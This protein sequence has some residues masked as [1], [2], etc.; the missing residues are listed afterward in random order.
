M[1][2]GREFWLRVNDHRI[3]FKETNA[4]WFEAG[5]AWAAGQ[6]RMWY[7]NT[8]ATPEKFITTEAFEDIAGLCDAMPVFMKYLHDVVSKDI[9][10]IRFKPSVI[11]QDKLEKNFQDLRGRGGGAQSLT[12]FGL[13]FN[14]RTINMCMLNDFLLRLN[15]E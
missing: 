5:L 8:I 7:R 6:L 10:G 9:P 3:Y 14:L 11:T 1:R 15:I 2:I 12:V 13:A 4:E